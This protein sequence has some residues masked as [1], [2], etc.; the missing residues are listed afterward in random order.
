[1]IA[2]DAQGGA[3]ACF[4]YRHPGRLLLLPA[5]APSLDVAGRR[6]LVDGIAELARRLDPS[7]IAVAL[8]GWATRL[9][10]P[11]EAALRA[12]I[13][14]LAQAALDAE[15][16]LRSARSELARIDSARRLAVGDVDTVL[17]VLPVILASLGAVPHVELLERHALPFEL[18]ARVVVLVVEHAAEAPP[19]DVL[20]RAREAAARA[21]AELGAPVVPIVLDVTEN[22]RP[23]ESRQGPRPALR[24]A[25]RVAGVAVTTG[26]SLLR[27]WASRDS[28]A[29]EALIDAT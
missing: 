8:P 21:G 15:R 4:A 3:L 25:A 27:A 16:A 13:T 12:R 24:A 28:G 1:V 23:P 7:S 2:R 14:G 19:D 29:L 26:E 11:G 17:A 5:P 20:G 9:E 10:L 18:G 22:L 6:A